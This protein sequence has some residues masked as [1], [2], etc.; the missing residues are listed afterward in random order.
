MTPQRLVR[1]PFHGIDWEDDEFAIPGHVPDEDLLRSLAAVGLL[2][3][4]VLWEKTPGRFVIVDGFRRLSWLRVH[5]SEAHALVYPPSFDPK[6]L[7]ALRLEAKV[8]SRPLNL[9]E[10]A[11][12]MAR[13]AERIPEDDFRLRICRA[14]GVPPTEESL[15]QWRSVAAWPPS[16]LA[17]LAQGVIAEKAALRLAP[18]SEKDREAFLELLLV[19]RCTASLQ[20]EILD[21]CID[22]A[23]RDGIP[24][25]ALVENS[26]M[27]AI[28][29][30]EKRNR[31]EK[32]AAVRDLVCRWRFPR[33]T[34][35]MIRVERSIAALHLP[36]TVSLVPPPF[37]EGD[38]WELRVRF[39]TPSELILCLNDME[40]LCETDRFHALFEEADRILPMDM[41][42]QRLPPPGASA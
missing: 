23:Q 30:D 14:M 38:V 20:V 6:R 31:R 27:Q 2:H 22:I 34:A 39:R 41:T 24:L 35:K 16:H 18:L 9:A 26:E 1:I 4:P 33:V 29:K 37:L 17:G 28:L 32:T 3:P 42:A 8:C 5:T 15:Q 25:H 21:R 11:Q 13:L 40:A 36:S 7:L 19:L 12:I 10:K